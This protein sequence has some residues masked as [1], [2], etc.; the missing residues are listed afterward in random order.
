MQESR[1]MQAKSSPKGCNPV[2]MLG[3]PC[4]S[5]AQRRSECGRKRQAAGSGHAGGVNA[6]T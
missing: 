2:L 1:A 6:L 5:G 4:H 3:G